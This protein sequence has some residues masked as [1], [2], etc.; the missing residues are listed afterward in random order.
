M[1]LP[2]PTIKYSDSVVNAGTFKGFFGRL[3]P[4]QDAGGILRLGIIWGD[5]PSPEVP[6]TDENTKLFYDVD[7]TS[8]NDT[9][10]A[11]RKERNKALSDLKVLEEELLHSE[12]L[13]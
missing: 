4:D 10:E 2:K 8:M 9:L 13:T 12:G 1:H 11:I 3:D 5:S 7:S 6:V